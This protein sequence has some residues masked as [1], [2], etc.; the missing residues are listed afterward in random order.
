M[1]LA[2]VGGIYEIMRVFEEGTAAGMRHLGVLHD[3]GDV[4]VPA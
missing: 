3:D 4:D 1:M 2:L